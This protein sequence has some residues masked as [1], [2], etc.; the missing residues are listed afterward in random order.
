MASKPRWRM[1]FFAS[2]LSV[3][4]AIAVMGLPVPRLYHRPTPWNS[5]GCVTY[6]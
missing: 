6:E 5:A 3:A 1:S 2:S 4:T